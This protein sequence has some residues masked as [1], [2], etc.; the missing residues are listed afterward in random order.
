MLH[1]QYRWLYALMISVVIILLGIMKDIQPASQAL[2]HLKTTKH[3]LEKQLLTLTHKKKSP[4]VIRQRMDGLAEVFD[5]TS[6][7]GVNIQS[8]K[9]TS[10]QVV[11]VLQGNFQQL[12]AFI[13]QLIH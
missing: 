12:S 10:S 7:H 3:T 5:L 11:L 8:V 4:Q 2:R 1:Y 13:W 9:T 6:R